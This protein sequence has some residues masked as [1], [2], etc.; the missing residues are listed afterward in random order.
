M[1]KIVW[2]ASYPKSGNTWLRLL[3]SSCLN[4]GQIVDINAIPV[5]TMLASDRAVFD[6]RLGVAAADLPDDDV[7]ALKAGALRAEVADIEP[8]L[9]IKTHDARLQVAGGEWTV[10]PD[11]TRGAIYLIR[12]PRDVA[13]SL[14]R[15]FGFELD[16]AIDFM[17]KPGR[18]AQKRRAS[19]PSHLPQLWSDWSGNVES[20]LTS[21]PFPAFVVRYERLR[22]AP[23]EVVADILE[24]MGLPQPREVVRDAVAATALDKLRAQEAVGGFTEAHRAATFF[25]AGRVGGW[26]ELLTPRQVARIESD[27]GAM[28]RRL[29]YLA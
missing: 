4:R 28:M 18:M 10:P 22:A 8:P 1:S 12:D 7:L 2:L 17:A 6:E 25:G 29:G 20:W 24:A 23:E 16:R 19:L 21:V 15:H 5:G 14:A 26:K 9:F 27:H 13:P 3:L 11:I